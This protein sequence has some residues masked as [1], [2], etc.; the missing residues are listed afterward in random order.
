V[1]LG[2][3]EDSLSNSKFQLC[4]VCELVKTIM[5][6]EN[7]IHEELSQK[8]GMKVMLSDLVHFDIGL[9]GLRGL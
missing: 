9:R 2:N 8:L 4:E 6:S 3:D 1:N 5:K 7:V